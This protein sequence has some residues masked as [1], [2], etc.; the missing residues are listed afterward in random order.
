MSKHKEA[1]GRGYGG[2]DHDKI[3]SHPH[4]AG[5]AQT[6]SNNIKEVLRLLWRFETSGQAS[7]R[8][9]SVMSLLFNM[10]SRFVIAFVKRRKHR[11][12]SW[13][14]SPS[15]VILESKKIKRIFHFY[16]VCFIF[17]ISYSALPFH[18]VYVF[19]LFFF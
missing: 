18:L 3:K 11:L 2:H 17:S 15:A 7:D 14:Q 6:E 16:L 19:H 1:S 9:L 13:L 8:P 12:N 10:L 4:Q 5:D